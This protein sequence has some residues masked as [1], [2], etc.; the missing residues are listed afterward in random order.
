[1]HE[2]AKDTKCESCKDSGKMDRRRLLRVVGSGAGALLLLR[3]LPGCG[4]NTGSPPTGP[5]SAGNLAAVKVNSL[6]IMS[7]NVVIGRDSNGLYAMSA[8]CTHAGC[9]LEDSAGTI[10]AGLTCPCHGSAFDGNGA[11]IQGPARSPL[12]HYQVTV[13][14]DGSITADGGKPVAATVRT[15]AG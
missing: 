14:A 5:V 2:Q 7:S 6:E 10:A 4:Q 8:I 9:V 1:M 12:Q 11:V 3:A 15:P 13:A